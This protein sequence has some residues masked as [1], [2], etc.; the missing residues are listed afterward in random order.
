M[1]LLLTDQ[2]N[3]SLPVILIEAWKAYLELFLELRMMH[4]IWHAPVRKV[5]E[6]WG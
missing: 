1:M 4:K 6:Y 2:R 5:S 3:K